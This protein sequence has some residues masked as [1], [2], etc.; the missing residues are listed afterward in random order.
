V[1]GVEVLDNLVVDLGWVVERRWW[2]VAED[3]V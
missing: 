3:G 1:N 2:L